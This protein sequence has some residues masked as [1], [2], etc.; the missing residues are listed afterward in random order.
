MNEERLEI[1]RDLVVVGLATRTSV[2][3]AARDIPALWG[4]FVEENLQSTLPRR[5][6]DAGV[7][8][9]YCDYEGD[10]RAPYTLVLGVA[11]EPTTEIPRGMRRVRIPTG[12]YARFTVTGDPTQVIWPTWAHINGPWGGRPTRRF[13]AD[14]ERYAPDGTQ[15]VVVGVQ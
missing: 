14:Y 8:A 3:S 10:E 13:I 15:A 2:Q 5:A 4:R 9:V 1:A 6:D 12:S 7:Y 11:V